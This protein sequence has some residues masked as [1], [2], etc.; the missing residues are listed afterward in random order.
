MGEGLKVEDSVVFSSILSKG[1]AQEGAGEYGETILEVNNL[2][3]ENENGVAVLNDCT[4]QIRGKEIFGIA[5]VAGNGQQSLAECLIGLRPITKGSAAIAGMAVAKTDTKEIFDGG[6]SY[7]PQDRLSDGYLPTA[8][9]AH[10]LIL[11]YHRNQPFNNRGFLNWAKIYQTSRDQISEYNIMTP[12]EKDVGA[13]LS[14]GNIQRVMLARA[15]AHPSELLIAHNPTR[16][17]DIRSMDFIYKK[18]LE[19]KAD[20]KAT[21]LISEDLD[22]LFRMCDRIATIYNGEIVGVLERGEF[23]KYE[24]GRMMSGVQAND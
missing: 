24:I 22:E 12:S 19:R 16:G 6:V 10:N 13:N 4:F 15:L 9:V 1:E 21:L 17:L 7:I 8:S 3:A 14:G 11:G 23:D 20:G 5:G 18:M 2:H